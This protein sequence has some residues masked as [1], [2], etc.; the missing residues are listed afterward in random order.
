MKNKNILLTYVSILT[1]GMCGFSLS[2]TAK[3]TALGDKLQIQ[4]EQLLESE[5]DAKQVKVRVEVE[6]KIQSNKRTINFMDFDLNND[7]VLARDEVGEKLFYIFDKDRNH[8]IDNIEMKKI[9]IL[10][11]TPMKKKT[12]EVIDYNSADKSQKVSVNEEEFLEKSQLSKFDQGEDGLS[13]L[14]FLGMTFNKVDVRSDHMIDLY[15][16]KRAYA[17]SVRPRHMEAYSYNN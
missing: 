10:V 2:V 1:I 9:G 12:I 8:L 5:P 4:A 13:P 3:D 6:P 17:A 11:F 16:W 14:D 15:E 7:G